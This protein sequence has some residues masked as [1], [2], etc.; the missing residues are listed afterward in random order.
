MPSSMRC[1]SAWTVV[2]RAYMPPS[3]RM[4]GDAPAASPQGRCCSPLGRP[5]DRCAWRVRLG[6]PTQASTSSRA[7]S[8]GCRA[9]CPVGEAGGD[10]E[11]GGEGGKDQRRLR[12]QPVGERAG[13]GGGDRLADDDGGAE[14]RHGGRRAAGGA[15]RRGEAVE[16]DQRRPD[17]EPEDGEGDEQAGLR[18]RRA[19]ADGR[20]QQ[21]GAEHEPAGPRGEP[22]G[23]RRRAEGQR[24][25]AD[26]H[27]AV[28]QAGAVAVAGRGEEAGE[29]GEGG[30]EE[31]ADAERAGD[32]GQQPGGQQLAGGRL[33]RALLGRGRLEPA[34]RV[35]GERGDE[36]G[37]EHGGAGDGDPRGDRGGEQPD[38]ERADDEDHLVG[39]GLVG[40]G[41]VEQLLPAVGLRPAA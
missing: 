28:E 31:D 8:A 20:G 17:A 21:Q 3:S 6:L 9:G 2:D 15:E 7:G 38:E 29:A 33:V 16:R 1:G 26:A 12:A 36:D 13:D 27:D 32:D 25:G 19:V 14:H 4:V 5:T 11:R 10:D 40:H 23:E 24:R 18:A 22:L 35:Q 34:G 39:G 30:A 37:G 41:A